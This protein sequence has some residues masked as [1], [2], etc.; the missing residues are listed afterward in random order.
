VPRHA[1]QEAFIDL[2]TRLAGDGSDH[3]PSWVVIDL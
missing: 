2:R 3:D 1:Q